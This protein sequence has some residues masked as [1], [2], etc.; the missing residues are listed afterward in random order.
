MIRMKEYFDLAA[1]MLIIFGGLFEAPL[2]VLY[3]TFLGI[4]KTRHLV[5]PW[6]G[7]VIGIAVASAVCSPPDPGSMMLVMVPMMG[8]YGITIVLSL[9]LSRRD[10]PGAIAPPPLLNPPFLT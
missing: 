5:R 4:L 6:R 2:L 3:L 10:A 7:I 1:W 8:L 9:F